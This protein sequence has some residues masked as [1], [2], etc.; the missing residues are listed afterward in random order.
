LFCLHLRAAYCR[1]ISRTSLSFNL[2]NRAMNYFNR[3]LI[4]ISTLE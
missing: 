2:V 1:A 4:A 3:A